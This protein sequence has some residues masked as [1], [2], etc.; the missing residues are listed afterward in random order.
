MQRRNIPGTDLQV[1]PVCLGT[2]QFAGSSD[3]QDMTWG[4]PEEAASI[5]TV[6]AALDAGIN[7]FDTAEGYGFANQAEKVL[8]KALV[9][10]RR[11][12]VIASK[13]LGDH[14]SE[15]ELE[16]SLL[17]SLQALQTDFLDIYQIHWAPNDRSGLADAI[18]ALKR[19]QSLGRIRHFAVCNFGVQDLET[20]TA[21][22]V[23]LVTNQLPYNLIWRAIETDIV[24]ACT[25]KN[26]GILAY[27]PLQ[28]G[29]LSGKFTSADQVP[30]GRQRTR[31][32]ASSRTALSRHGQAGHEDLT[33]GTLQRVKDIS[34]RAGVSM[35]G[36]ALSWV[37]N[38]PGVVSAIVGATSV[39]Q[40]RQSANAPTLSADVVQQLTNATAELKDALGPDP[41][42]WAAQSRYK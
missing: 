29:L 40:I 7:F 5:A 21:A 24:P 37:L 38:Q 20:V 17:Q 12:C 28:Q 23:S 22:G 11:D 18:A 19:Q 1:S 39:E 34:T 10:R 16:K 15:V 8:G 27:S 6:H 35:A 3:H 13:V 30:A 4:A 26:I 32:F 9:G 36:A 33:F 2:W 41:D 25:A 42:M 31:H 14:L